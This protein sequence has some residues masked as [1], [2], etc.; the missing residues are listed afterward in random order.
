MHDSVRDSFIRVTAPLDGQVSHMYCD[1]NRIVRCAIGVKLPDADSATQMVWRWRDTNK[2]ANASQVRAE[3]VAI[4]QIGQTGPDNSRNSLFYNQY[5]QL[6]MTA[7][8]IYKTTINSLLLMEMDS[9]LPR[10]YR[11]W[12]ADAQMAILQMLW[13]DM[14]INPELYAAMEQEDWV[15]AKDLMTHDINA[16]V[17]VI[18]QL[19]TNAAEVVKTNSN[20][21]K[22]TALGV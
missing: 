21:A 12:P 18:Q 20:K 4:H 8:E 9:K 19:L 13:A 14:E 5:A 6:E 1:N 3:W 22:L 10:S 2:R 16:R 11:Y 15:S 7:T 17:L